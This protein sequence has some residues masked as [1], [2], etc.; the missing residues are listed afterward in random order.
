MSTRKIGFDG[1]LPKIIFQL[2]SNM[3]IICFSGYSNNEKENV[4]YENVRGIGLKS[5][6]ENK[7]TEKNDFS[8][9]EGSKRITPCV[10]KVKAGDTKQHAV[11]SEATMAVP[12]KAGE[13]RDKNKS[14]KVSW[15]FQLTSV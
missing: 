7:R 10:S 15:H 6:N 5:S 14:S 13:T 12:V 3:Y 4:P 11:G 1:E 8:F 2:S 9:K